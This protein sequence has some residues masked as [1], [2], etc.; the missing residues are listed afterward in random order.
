MRTTFDTRRNFISRGGKKA[1][2]SGGTNKTY[3]VDLD[4]P[5][6]W[7]NLREIWVDSQP[8]PISKEYEFHY[9]CPVEVA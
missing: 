5:K 4:L 2:I 7:V 8:T 3:L 6:T 9:C 1:I